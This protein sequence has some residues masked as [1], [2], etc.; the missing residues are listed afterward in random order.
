MIVN[1][2]KKTLKKFSLVRFP[3]FGGKKYCKL[4]QNINLKF[5]KFFFEVSKNKPKLLSKLPEH[6]FPLMEEQR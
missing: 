1:V 6:K 4:K 2:R 5:W 3:F